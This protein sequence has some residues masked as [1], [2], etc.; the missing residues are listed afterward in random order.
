MVDSWWRNI[1][2]V[3]GFE[4]TGKTTTMKK[5][6]I[7]DGYSYYHPNHN[8]TDVTIG[9][10]NSW[11]IGYGI[12][13]LLSQ[14]DLSNTKILIDRG[15]AS[16]YVYGILNGNPLDKRVIEWYKNNDFFHRGVSHVIVKHTDMT[17]ARK[18]YDRC[19][20]ERPENPNE[21]S[22]KFDRFENFDEYYRKYSYASTLFDEAY[23]KLNI[24]PRTIYN[25][26]VG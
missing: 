20:S 25:Q 9:R 10:D 8:L 6:L 1:V 15:V 13:D 17:S 2:I 18:I 3:E 5:M 4:I 14:I 26:Y 21:L 22:A 23:E 12:F 7:P 24:V 19:L 11:T 16:S